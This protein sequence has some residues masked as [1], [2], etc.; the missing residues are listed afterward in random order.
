MGRLSGRQGGQGRGKNLEDPGTQPLPSLSEAYRP[1]RKVS[2]TDR[3]SPSGLPVSS[4]HSIPPSSSQAVSLPIS[5]PTSH[6]PRPLCIVQELMSGSHMAPK[7]ILILPQLA[8]Q[9]H[10]RL[11]LPASP[12]S[13][14]GTGESETYWIFMLLPLTRALPSAKSS[15][16]RLKVTSVVFSLPLLLLCDLGISLPPRTLVHGMASATAATT[17]T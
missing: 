13:Y 16:S 9:A 10:L 15:S 1:L 5:Y 2:T 17:R 12:S 6:T 3:F 7:P 4:P 14:L 8:F 11:H